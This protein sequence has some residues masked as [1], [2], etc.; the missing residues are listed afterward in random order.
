MGVEGT[1]LNMVKAI[2]HKLTS[3]IILSG[4]KNWKSFLEDQAQDKLVH[5]GLFY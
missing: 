5:S 2:Y 4:G 3:S 1:F